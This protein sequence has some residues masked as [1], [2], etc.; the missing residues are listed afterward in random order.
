MEPEKT[1]GFHFSK[2]KSPHAR[3][4]ATRHAGNLFM[5]GFDYLKLIFTL[6]NQ[7]LAPDTFSA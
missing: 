6:P 5:R 2:E 4:L 1:A 7:V 3:R